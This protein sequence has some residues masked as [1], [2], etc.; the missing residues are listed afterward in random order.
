VRWIHAALLF[1]LLSAV[2]CSS[3]DTRVA[4][5]TTCD[6]VRRYNTSLGGDDDALMSRL[7]DR[8]ATVAKRERPSTY[9]VQVAGRFH[10]ALRELRTGGAALPRSRQTYLREEYQK[11][12]DALRA[13]CEVP[14]GYPGYDTDLAPPPSTT[15]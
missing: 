2:S 4:A 9:V 8:I 3:G 15:P 13:S 5:S 7:E 11:T 1:V 6:A 12:L 10:A 14:L